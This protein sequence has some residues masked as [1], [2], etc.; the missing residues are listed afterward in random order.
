MMELCVLMSSCDDTQLEYSRTTTR[1][2]SCQGASPTNTFRYITI[3][4]D[5]LGVGYDLSDQ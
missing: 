1:P 4:S 5:N 2:L 3:K